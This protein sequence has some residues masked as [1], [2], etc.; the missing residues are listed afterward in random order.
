MVMEGTLPFGDDNMET[1]PHTLNVPVGLAMASSPCGG[2]GGSR[3]SGDGDDLSNHLTTVS[4]ED[5]AVMPHAPTVP[6]TDSPKIDSADDT[7]DSNQPGG[8]DIE[9]LAARHLNPSL[10]FSGDI[11]CHFLFMFKK[12]TG[13]MCCADVSVICC[14]MSLCLFYSCFIY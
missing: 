7:R 14:A 11:Q 4:A 12:E 10:K 1:L 13:Y 8:D 3:D 6:S 9:A 2:D 5:P